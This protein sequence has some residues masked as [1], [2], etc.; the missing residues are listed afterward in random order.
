MNRKHFYVAAC[1][2]GEDAGIYTMEMQEGRHRRLAFLP[3]RGASYLCFSPDARFLYL[4]NEDGELGGVASFAIEGESL[5]LVSQ[6]LS[7]GNRCCHV[8]VSGDGRFLYAAN[9]GKGQLQEYELNPATGEISR[10]SKMV[11]HEGCGINPAR[12]EKAHVHSCYFTPDDKYLI[13]IDLGLDAIDAYPWSPTTGIDADGAKRS[14][15]SPAGSGPRHLVWAPGRKD[16]AYLL[17]ELLSTITVLA[18]NDGL[19]T[20]RQTVDMLP[21]SLRVYSKASAIRISPDGRFLY[22]SN[23]GYDTIAG[24]RI[25]EDGL[26]S[27]IGLWFCG[28]KGPRDF[29]FIPDGKLFCGCE[30]SN[31][32]YVFDYNSENGELCPDGNVIALMPRPICII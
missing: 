15:I 22:G 6:I 21:P 17:N 28:G 16:I 20:Q 29:N 18:Y 27:Q 10:M 12:Q 2:T 7:P 24:Y 31:D 3:Y 11:Q 4:A 1:G 8:T 13:S 23:R 32:A 25:C 26:L 5:R 19:F 30:N 9:Y 14:V